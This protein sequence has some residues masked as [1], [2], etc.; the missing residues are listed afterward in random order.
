MTEVGETVARVD[1]LIKE[2]AALQKLCMVSSVILL[3]FIRLMIQYYAV[4]PSTASSDLTPVI[5][6]FLR[7]LKRAGMV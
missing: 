1:M 4:G 5:R 7:P 2:A 6:V 3:T